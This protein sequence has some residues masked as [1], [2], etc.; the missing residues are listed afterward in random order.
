MTVAKANSSSAIMIGFGV[1]LAA[2]AAIA[3]L[4]SGG[5]SKAA[6]PAPAPPAK[7]GQQPAPPIAPDLAERYPGITMIDMRS[8]APPEQIDYIRGLEKTTAV[9]LHQTGF[10]GWK[11]SNPLWPKIK[12]HFVVRQDGRVQINYDPEV[13]MTTGSNAANS[14][15]VTI[16]H[17]GNFPNANGNAFKPEKFGVSH[18][19]DHPAQVEAS[20]KLVAA[21]K[22]ISPN[23]TAVFAHRQWSDNRE[24]CPGPEIWRAVGEWAKQH[25][26]LTDGGPG[27]KWDPGE[28][29]P[30]T[31]RAPL[32]A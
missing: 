21:L 32:V 23:M 29:I 28:P 8:K 16:E 18:L 13:R 26:G 22:A 30:D 5:G 6:K 11:D 7:P 1:A 31:W 15:A 12:A 25:L 17:E 20:R 19:K 14:F 9:V 10:F 4:A 2:V 27:W 3:M 24:N